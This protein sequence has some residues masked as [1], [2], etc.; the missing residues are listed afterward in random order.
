MEEAAPREILICLQMI[1]PTVTAQMH[2]VGVGKNGKPFI[3]D[4][5]EI[6]NARQKFRAHLA[7]YQIMEPLEGPLM[8]ETTWLFPLPES[9]KHKAGDWKITRPDTDNLQK[10][11]KDEMQKMGF[12]KDDAQ[13]CAEEIQKFYSTSPGI[14]IMLRQLSN[15]VA[16]GGIDSGHEE[17]A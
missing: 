10:L 5:P 7:A 12:F 8:M 6:K 4:T 17:E 2:K 3:Y 16:S 15:Y 14:V 1:P 9:G 11:L 13:V